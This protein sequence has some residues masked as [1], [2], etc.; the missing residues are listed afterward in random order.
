MTSVWPSLTGKR[1]RNANARAFSATQDDGGASRKGDFTGAAM[2]PQAGAFEAVVG[3]KGL[4]P[5]TYGLKART[6]RLRSPKADLRRTLRRSIRNC[7]HSA[8][9]RERR[10]RL[11]L[12]EEATR[13]D[14][15][16]RA[17]T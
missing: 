11:R 6:S 1:S 17:D 13:R 12:A 10:G 15:A 2:V 8:R 3:R 5:L 7:G 14:G 4:E 9:F 16:G